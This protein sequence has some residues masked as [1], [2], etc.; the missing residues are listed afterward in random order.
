MAAIAHARIDAAGAPKAQPLASRAPAAGS[1]PG[2][3]RIEVEDDLAAVA[4]DWRAFESAADGTVFQTYDYLAC[5]QRHVGMLTGV[6]PAIVIGRDAAGA[7]LFLLPLAVRRAGLARALEFLGSD[8]CDYNGP[9]LARDFTARAGGQF[10]ALWRAIAQSLRAHPRLA[11][12]FVRLTKMPAE[13][14]GQPNPMLALGVTA[15]PSGAYLTTLGDT[16]ETF[17]TAKRSSSTR[18]R[19]R[20]KRKRLSDLGAVGLV[21][22][23]GA[24]TGAAL[25]ILMAQKAR[26]FARMGVANLFANP[27][28]PEFY[29]DLAGGE[30]TGAL[31][32]VSRL[33]V[34]TVPAA[35]NL[36][37]VY[38][39][40][41]YHLLASYDDGE[42]SKFGPGA[43]HL[44]DLMQYA[45]EHGCRVFDFTIGDE[46]YKRD[47]S[48]KELVLY[49]HVS[50]AT[51]RGAL[52]AWPYL[53]GQ[54]AK[55]FIK[56]TPAVWNAVSK[57]R[58]LIGALRAR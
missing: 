32:H 25:D 41:Y 17:Y 45:I 15:H 58:E 35:L 6:R 3:I 49:D 10:P 57:A 52:A 40:R 42:V 29:R 55:R 20:T 36:G 33:D 5:W 47:W 18:R 19:D 51:A 8:L 13:V 39:G 53:A 54:R 46:S 16:W 37:L 50:A 12:D 34:G 27:G 43:A 26:S 31:A 56:Q 24:D 14:G 11:Y 30:A 7:I 38:K 22:L 4:A 28:Y 9:L 44:H 2:D 48:D 1:L 21:N 23:A